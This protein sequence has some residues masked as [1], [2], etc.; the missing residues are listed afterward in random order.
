MRDRADLV[1]AA[2]WRAQVRARS[3]APRR[4]IAVDD[5]EA[6][7]LLLGL[8]ER[9]VDDQARA[10]LAQRGRRGGRQQPGHRAELA[11]PGQTAPEPP[12]ACPGSAPRS[13]SQSQTFSD[14]LLVVAKDRIEHGRAS[15]RAVRESGGVCRSAAGAAS[16]TSGARQCYR[17]VPRDNRSR[18]ADATHLS[19]IDPTPARSGDAASW[20][21]QP[22]P[23]PTSG[24]TPF[25]ALSVTAVMP[26]S[27]R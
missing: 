21:S 10:A 1:G 13:S 19:L 24:A 6:E 14:P 9:P 7:Q 18:S 12:S 3:R 20:R 25:M 16:S 15:F 2:G 27:P 5:I 4:A 11:A 8:G 23:R 26:M 22:A 17:S